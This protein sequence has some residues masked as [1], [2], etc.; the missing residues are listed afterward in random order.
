MIFYPSCF[1]MSYNRV[2][3]FSQKCDL[4]CIPDQGFKVYISAE[5]NIVYSGFSYNKLYFCCSNF[6]KIPQWIIKH[7]DIDI[8][9]QCSLASFSIL[10]ILWTFKKNYS[11]IGNRIY[12]QLS[13]CSVKEFLNRPML[14]ELFS[15]FPQITILNETRD[16]NLLNDF[17]AASH[18]LRR[19]PCRYPFES[20]TMDSEGNIFQCPYS[21]KII[22]KFKNF[23]SL[24]QDPAIL[25]FLAAQLIGDLNAFPK[26]S[27]C[28][29]WIDGWLGEEKEYCKN[30]NGEGFSLLWEG[31][32]CSIKR[33][34]SK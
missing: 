11:D 22:G 32:S 31:H 10:D 1:F 29:Y 5:C 3:V 20:V 6:T 23:S 8:V 19:R 34:K 9:F 33:R 4:S 18:L 12:L 21:D 30:N 17:V 7:Q 15:I 25:N 24:L 26:C 28:P 27:C 13:D 2:A 16:G 14:D